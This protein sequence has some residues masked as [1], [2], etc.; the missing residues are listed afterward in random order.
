MESP[1][2]QMTGSSTLFFVATGDLMA[3]SLPILGPSRIYTTSKHASY[4]FEDQNT[5]CVADS[6]LYPV[7]SGTSTSR[8]QKQQWP[9]LSKLA[10][11]L[12]LELR[13][14][15]SLYLPWRKVAPHFPFS[16]ERKTRLTCWWSHIGLVNESQVDGRL[17]NSL[18]LRFELGLFDPPESQAYHNISLSEVGQQSTRDLNRLMARESMVLM[19]NPQPGLKHSAARHMIKQ[20]HQHT[21]SA[22]DARI[23]PFASGKKV[24]VVG[25]HFNASQA[26]VGNYLGQACPTYGSFDCITTLL[27][28]VVEANGDGLVQ[29]AQGCDVKSQSMAGFDPALAIAQ[30]GDVVVLAMGIDQSVEGESHDRTSIDLPGVQP[31]FALKVLDLCKPTALVLI[32]GG[33]LAIERL[34]EHPCADYLAIISA[35]YPGPEGADAIAAALFGLYSPGGKLSNTWYPSKYISEVSMTSM[36]FTEFP[37]RTYKYYQGVP[38]FTFGYGLS[39]TSFDM[40]LCSESEL[41]ADTHQSSPLRIK[42]N[43]QPFS[44]LATCQWLTCGWYVVT[45]AGDL[46]LPSPPPPMAKKELVAF[47][48]VSLPPNAS[49]NITFSVHIADLGAVLES[50][51]RV[52]TQG[53]FVLDITNGVALH[54]LINVHLY[55]DPK[56][57]WSLPL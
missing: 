12:T 20:K 46:D 17:Y 40:K 2:V 24:A 48:R 28:G 37:G 4:S 50:G 31:Q 7:H 13:T 26:L 39:Y 27:E 33:M 34:L 21:Q 18:K 3:T 1:H 55:G 56:T 16:C 38:T 42:V 41:Y 10:A 52:V 47:Q 19:R 57:V 32:H 5:A 51:K 23:L 30:W 22:A 25:P 44:S 53:S 49:R 8:I 36:S 9:F 15:S 14:T 45:V 29:A 43:A 54:E 35:G 11:M 6:G